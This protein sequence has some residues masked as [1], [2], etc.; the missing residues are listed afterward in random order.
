MASWYDPDMNINDIR[1]HLED[2]GF[3]V[4]SQN[5]H[6]KYRGPNGEILVVPCSQGEGRG[7]ANMI[8]HLRRMGYEPLPVKVGGR[9]RAKTIPA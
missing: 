7:L 8:A 6:V 3:R 9:K 4:V 1:R 5:K 2:I